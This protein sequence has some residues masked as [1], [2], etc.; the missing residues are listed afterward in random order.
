MK[1]IIQQVEDNTAV[2]HH[3]QV[4]VEGDTSNTPASAIAETYKIV[5]SN[6]NTKEKSTNE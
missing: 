3:P 4:T 2:G 1:V 5:L 6:L